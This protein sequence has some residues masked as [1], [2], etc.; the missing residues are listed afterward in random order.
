M[1]GYFHFF[2]SSYT[3]VSTRYLAKDDNGELS[4][5]SINDITNDIINHLQNFNKIL[6]ESLDSQ[7]TK[8][9]ITEAVTKKFISLTK[10]EKRIYFLIVH[11]KKINTYDLSLHI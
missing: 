3:N 11:Q 2:I 8:D 7:D 4:D 10:D 9:I 1:Q 5:D 6:K